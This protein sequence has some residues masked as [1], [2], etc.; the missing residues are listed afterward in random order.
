MAN[1]IKL[2]SKRCSGRKVNEDK[3]G[4]L[5]KVLN[6]MTMNK[7]FKNLRGNVTVDSVLIALEYYDEVRV[8]KG[9]DYIRICKPVNG[10][11]VW[12]INAHQY[13]FN[14]DDVKQGFTYDSRY[15]KEGVNSPISVNYTGEQYFLKILENLLK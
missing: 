10:K 14:A 6:E 5:L 15:L 1:L 7:R 4:E 13:G 3:H 2:D 8:R 9:D 12:Y 11:Y